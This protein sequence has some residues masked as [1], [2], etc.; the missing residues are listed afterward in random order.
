MS[1]YQDCQICRSTWGLFCVDCLSSKGGHYYSATSDRFFFRNGCRTE[2]SI[3]KMYTEM[4]NGMIPGQK[5]RD[6]G[7]YTTADISPPIYVA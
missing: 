5:L 6:V 3:V 4:F 2:S 7:E 1:P